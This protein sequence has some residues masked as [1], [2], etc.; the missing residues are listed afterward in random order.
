MQS[1][2]LSPKD[3]LVGVVVDYFS[4]AKQSW[5]PVRI[6]RVEPETGSVEIDFRAGQPIPKE[7]QPKKLRRH[8]KPSKA[9]LEWVVHVIGSTKFADEMSEIFHRHAKLPKT[10]GNHREPVLFWNS[11]SAVA[12]DLDVQLGVCGSILVLEEEACPLPRRLHESVAWAFT[13]A[14]FASAFW[15]LLHRTL[16]DYGQTLAIKQVAPRRGESCGRDYEVERELKQGTYGQVRVVRE[17][18]TG[19]RLAVKAIK[20]AFMAG[21]EHLLDLEVEH[22]RRVDH[23]NI[24]KLHK[25]YEDDL[26]VYLVMDLCSGGDLQDSLEAAAARKVSLSEDYVTHVMRQL[27]RAVSHVH[28]RGIIHLDIKG[29]NIMLTPRASTAPCFGDASKD[30]LPHVML[31]D[32][33]VAQLFQPGDYQQDFPGGTPSTMAPEVWRGEITPAADVFSCGIVMWELCTLKLDPLRMELTGSLEDFIRQAL[34]FWEKGPKYQWDLMSHLPE[35]ARELAERMLRAERRERPS[36]QECLDSTFFTRARNGQPV[37]D[38]QNP[39]V[40]SLLGNL[41]AHASRSILYKSLALI[42]ARKSSATKLPVAQQA[43]L[44]L[45][46]SGTGFLSPG[47]VASV[48]M[49][50]GM[51]ADAAQTSARSMD[52]NR[53]GLIDWTE[54]VAAC[55]TL[56]DPM[57]EGT[58]RQ[59]FQKAAASSGGLLFERELSG[60]LP[61]HGPDDAIVRGLFTELSQ[62]ATGIDWQSFHAHFCIQD[63]HA[64]LLD[65]GSSRLS[66]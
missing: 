20:K 18:S 45:D 29:L 57:Y 33:G 34:Q 16:R 1:A 26:H 6:T 23:P 60:L 36:A 25:H 7:D 64:Q 42:V 32:L 66:L 30:E 50:C 15:K 4:S 14:Q 10:S 11:L 19:T 12:A 3:L 56:G 8:L 2:N 62:K 49:S 35:S 47:D 40:S 28:A 13:L 61:G 39:A 55:V 53:D 9:Q 65:G 54:F 59:H 31:I 52:L 22:L 58:L 38:K 27:M 48:L 24:V 51:S 63:K 43:F 46:T 37:L 5:L 17:K 21:A 41:A 44:T